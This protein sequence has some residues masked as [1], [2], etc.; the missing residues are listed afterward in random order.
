VN[1]VASPQS[2]TRVSSTTLD[3]AAG[4]APPTNR[5][6]DGGEPSGN[7][8]CV[9][10]ASPGIYFVEL[11]A[12]ADAADPRKGHSAPKSPERDKVDPEASDRED[13]RSANE[14]RLAKMSS[15]IKRVPLDATVPV[16]HANGIRLIDFPDDGMFFP[17]PRVASGPDVNAPP[18]P[19]IV[20]SKFLEVLG[21]RG[22][23]IGILF[24]RPQSGFRVLKEKHELSPK[25]RSMRITPWVRTPRTPGSNRQ[26]RKGRKRPGKDGP[27]VARFSDLLGE[28]DD[29]QEPNIRRLIP[30]DSTSTR[31]SPTSPT[32]SRDVD[33]A[34]T[35]ASDTNDADSFPLEPTSALQASYPVPF[36]TAHSGSQTCALGPCEPHTLSCNDPHNFLAWT[37]PATRDVTQ[38]L[39]PFVSP[40][41]VAPKLG[42]RARRRSAA[43]VHQKRRGRDGSRCLPFPIR[44][45]FC[46]FP[47][48]RT[49]Y[50]LGYNATGIASPY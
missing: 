28:L 25:S 43:D 29:T 16:K 7:S 35:D 11:Q 44:V 2:S 37:H 10:E 12:S 45:C 15:L 30:Q 26:A 49:S 9:G 13:T 24:P 3:A 6:A 8:L 50:S 33:D 22:V 23:A 20:Q 31:L 41:I 21:E 36:D 34:D 1:A 32:P 4:I 46:F 27:A 42:K 19:E 14:A 5:E 18:L 47:F 38:S 17:M 39:G 48:P 40:G